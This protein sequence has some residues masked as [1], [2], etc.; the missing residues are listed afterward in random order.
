MISLDAE[1]KNV[2]HYFKENFSGTSIEFSK[3]KRN[4]NGHILGFKFKTKVNNK[5]DY[6]LYFKSNDQASPIEN[7]LLIPKSESKF[8]VIKND[9]LLTF[10]PDDLDFEVIK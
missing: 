3:L 5:K 4:E 7:V 8:Y 1:L 6:T 9:F 10:T 2:E